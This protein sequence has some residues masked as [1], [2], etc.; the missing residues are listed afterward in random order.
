MSVIESV[1]YDK[2]SYAPGDVA[3][4]TVKG[5]WGRIDPNSVNTGDGGVLA[6]QLTV[7]FPV[8]IEDSTG[9]KWELVSNTGN[10]AVLTSVV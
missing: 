4:A 7:I 5:D 10:E 1:E 2:P 6:S 8:D 9:R 3:T